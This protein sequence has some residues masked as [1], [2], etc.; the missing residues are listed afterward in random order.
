[1]QAEEIQREH[2]SEK[3]NVREWIGVEVC[4]IDAGKRRNSE[5]EGERKKKD[6]DENERVDWETEMNRQNI[7]K[8]CHK[9]Q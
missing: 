7:T 4:G 6:E 3:D 8:I 5:E 2:R 1:M 9:I